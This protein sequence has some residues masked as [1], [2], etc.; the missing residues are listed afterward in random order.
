[1]GKDKKPKG[2]GEQLVDKITEWDGRK[3]PEPPV[4]GGGWQTNPD[5]GHNKRAR[6][7]KNGGKRGR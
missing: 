5:S 3:H 4:T 7:N 2:G 6:A 1:M